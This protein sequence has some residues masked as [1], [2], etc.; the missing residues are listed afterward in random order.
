MVSLSQSPTTHG[1]SRSHPPHIVSLFQSPQ[2][3]Y[4]LTDFCCPSCAGVTFSLLKQP[5]KGKV[6]DTFTVSL[7]SLS[8][9]LSLSFP[10]T[11]HG[12]SLSQSPTTHCLSLSPTTHGRSVSVTTEGDTLMDLLM[13]FFQC[14]I[15]ISL[16]NQPNKGKVRD[17]YI[18][19]LYYLPTPYSLIY[20]QTRHNN[21]L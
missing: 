12:L 15:T 14:R 11:T 20:Y 3:V 2:K 19:L 9:S 13:L 4:T 1:L 18:Y 6:R 8:L 10:V 7:Y 21:T 5:N 16:L 17:T